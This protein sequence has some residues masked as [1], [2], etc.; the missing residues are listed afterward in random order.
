MIL[1]YGVVLTLPLLVVLLSSLQG[2]DSINCFQCN[3][4]VDL[5]CPYIQPNQT[6][7]IYYKPC[8]GDFKGR[9]PFCRKI[10]QKIFER[11][12]MVRVVRKCGWER[13][14]K[15]DCYSASNDDHTETICQ[16]F[17]DACNGADTSSFSSYKIF[18]ALLVALTVSLRR[19]LQTPFSI[20]P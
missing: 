16:C 7:S 3:S 20:I 1:N 2:V 8:I 13:H 14:D 9:Q 12:D 10:E 18:T 4:M 5:D 6:S 17:S 11:D 19:S 15:L